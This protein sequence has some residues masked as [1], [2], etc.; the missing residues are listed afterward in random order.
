MPVSVFIL[1]FALFL[2][3]LMILS[4]SKV[5]PSVLMLNWNQMLPQCLL[6][7]LWAA[8]SSS[9]PHIFL[10]HVQPSLPLV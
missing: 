2:S 1:P 5:P 9:A 4:F 7:S 6:L 10:Q 3:V 8:E